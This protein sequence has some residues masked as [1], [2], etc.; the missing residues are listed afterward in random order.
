MLLGSPEAY[1]AAEPFPHVVTE[2]GNDVF[3]RLVREEFPPDTD[4]RWVRF[5][6]DD[7]RKLQGDDPS[8]WGLHTQELA[9][10][11]FHES[12]VKRL[13]RLTG[14]D[15]LMPST[16]GGGYHKV[17]RGGRLG[18]HTDFTRHE[19]GLYRRL[20]L[21]VFLNEVWDASWGG[22][23]VLGDADNGL[24]VGP[25]LGR[26]VVFTTSHRSW[27]GHPVELRCP[28]GR[29]RCSFAVYYYT[30]APPED[31]AGDQGTVFA[32]REAR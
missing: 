6:S 21:L 2:Y 13:E 9:R 31:Y 5:D 27:H 23:L 19:N 30:E 18:M 24:I 7:E 4:E 12:F 16:L 8:M 32:P 29:A 22:A 28:P 1:A 15:E 25:T 10:S 11:L 14:I 20:N 17:S 3:L 26:M